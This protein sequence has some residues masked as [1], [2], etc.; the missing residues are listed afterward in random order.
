MNNLNF[1]KKTLYKFFKWNIFSKEEIY[2][3][4][5]SETDAIKVFINQDYFNKEFDVEKKDNS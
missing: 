5:E 2:T 4:R 1:Y 3:E